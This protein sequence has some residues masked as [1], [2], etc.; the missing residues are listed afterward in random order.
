MRIWFFGGVDEIGGSKFLIDSGDTKI[1]L[2]FGRSYSK[3]GAYYSF[4]DMPRSIDE[5]IGIQALPKSQY[6]GLNLD[7]LY[8]SL[9]VPFNE[10]DIESEPE[11]PVSAVF[12]SHVHTDHYQYISLLNRRI[13]IYVGECGLNIL[14][15]RRV[16]ERRTLLSNYSYIDFKSVRSFKEIKINDLRIIPIHVDHSIPGAY[17]FIIEGPDGVIAYTGDFRRHGF[18]PELTDDFINQM[19]KYDCIDALLCEGT[20]IAES[21]FSS[22]NEVKNKINEIVSKSKQLIIGDFSDTD[23]DRFRTYYEAAKH[24]NRKL[25]IS[26]KQAIIFMAMNLCKGLENP[27]I[28]KDELICILEPEK[29]RYSNWEKLFLAF[30]KGEIDKSYFPD[31]ENWHWIKK[32]ISKRAFFT[33]SRLISIKDLP[34]KPDKYILLTSFRTPTDLRQ[35]KPPGGSIYIL[36]TSEPFNEERELKYE[37]LLNWLEFFG[38]P[39]IKA[40]ASGHATP[41]DIKDMIIEVNPKKLI[42]IHTEHS[43]MF[44]NMF[45]KCKIEVTIPKLGEHTE[46]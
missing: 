14:S 44:Q 46:I 8:S 18:K 19:L 36:S 24:N 6:R 39:L 34:Q 9:S 26:L 45:R 28:L 1:F 12:L 43:A 42:P 41:I 5:L 16:T 22:E 10:S 35:I 38:V 4:P 2:D 17:G 7:G 13:P 32:K 23:F 11:P 30:L 33:E 15:F 40:H 29:L 37:K 25:V 27:N 20:H 31:D 21:D 3:E